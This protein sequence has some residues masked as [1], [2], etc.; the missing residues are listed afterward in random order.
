MVALMVA[1]HAWAA[2]ESKTFSLLALVFM[3]LMA[4]LTCSIHF[5]ILTLGHQAQLAGLPWMPLL[6]EFKWP[7]VVYALDVLAWDVLFALAVFSVAPV[8]RGS[9]LAKWTRALLIVSGVLAVGGLSGVVANDMQLCSIGIIGYALVFPATAAL[10]A[11]IFHGTPPAVRQTLDAG[12]T[13]GATEAVHKT[14]T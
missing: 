1:V 4:G 9:R 7:S 11:I 6:L 10:L 3:S 2:P 14:G 13:T 12:I 5:V 8:F